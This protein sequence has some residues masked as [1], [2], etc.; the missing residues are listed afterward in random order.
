MEF[1]PETPESVKLPTFDLY[2]DRKHQTLDGFGAAF[3]ESCAINLMKLPPLLRQETLEGMFSHQ[4][5]AG[6]NLIRLPIGAS[7]FADASKGSYT[8]DDTPKNRPDPL[9]KHFS[10]ARDEKTFALLREARRLNPDLRVMIS[11]WSP[12]AWM[13]TSRKLNG[14]SLDWTHANSFANYFVKVIHELE[15]R[16]I[17]V[18][19]L[20]LQNEPGYSNEWYPS[21]SMEASEQSRF[22]A[23]YL[24]PALKKAHLKTRI[25]VHDHNWEQ[26]ADYVMEIL[27]NPRSRPDISGV[28]YH[29]YGGNRWQ[30]LETMRR[31]PRVPHLQTECTGSLSSDAIGD[32]QWWLD[33]QSLGAVAMGTT[34][35]LGW[36]LCLDEKGGPQNG[37]CSFCR[38]SVTTDFSEP[39]SPKVIYNPEYHALAQVSR[40]TTSA[41]QRIEVKSHGVSNP[42]GVAFV[43]KDGSFVFVAQNPEAAAVKFRVRTPDCSDV[44]SEIPAKGAVTLTWT[45]SL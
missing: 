2:P 18:H 25:F 20:T 32:F 42:Q 11:P 14:G 37:G 22:V 4:S 28:A 27:D 41:S 1:K 16:G 8:Y 9:F 6:F 3:T 29:C 17:P 26:S 13:K 45:P 12:P 39:A 24:G 35:A 34:G 10:M 43:N 5:G 44:T 31:H 7:D 30:M 19:S 23:D 40:F 38:G 21:M 33:N 36:N 15:K